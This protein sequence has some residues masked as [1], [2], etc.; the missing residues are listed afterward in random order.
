MTTQPTA[1][2]PTNP[3]TPPPLPPAPGPTTGWWNTAKAA[4]YMGTTPAAIRMKVRRGTLVPTGRNG[5][6]IM[7]TKEDLDSQ[8]CARGRSGGRPVSSTCALTPEEQRHED[9]THEED[10]PPRNSPG[11]SEQIHG[12]DRD[13]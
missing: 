2:S 13:P 8:L 1:P 3:T 10:G 11:R 4:A 12:A 7:F 9:G 5:R 6:Q